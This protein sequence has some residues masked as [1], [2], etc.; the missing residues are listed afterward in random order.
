MRVLEQTRRRF[1]AFGSCVLG[2]LIT[3]GFAIPLVGSFLG[4]ALRRAKAR[5]TEVG[6]LPSIPVHGPVK[7][8]FADKVEDAYIS[9]TVQRY[10]WV[11]GVTPAVGPDERPSEQTM[12]RTPAGTVTV[13]SPLCP[14]LGCDYEWLA[15]DKVFYCPCHESRY[16]LDG[17][18]LSG[19]A[20]RPLDTLP[21]QLDGGN[22]Y[23]AWERFEPGV[24][25][26][27]RIG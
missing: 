21:C 15:S 27:K 23:I 3:V 14:H 26:K 19:P 4:P 2:T 7:V 5:F 1:L 25:F 12:V 10:V 22:L 8:P 20:P 13:F 18:V 9:K 24:P 6:P 17:S 16:A 11:V